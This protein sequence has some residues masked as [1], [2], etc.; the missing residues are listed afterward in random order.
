MKTNCN[1]L[2]LTQKQRNFPIIIK[3]CIIFLAYLLLKKIFRASYAACSW[4]FWVRVLPDFLVQ[5][6]PI[7]HKKQCQKFFFFHA[8]PTKTELGFFWSNLD[9]REMFVV[10]KRQQ[11]DRKTKHA[12]GVEQNYHY[13]H[14]FSEL[15]YTN[16]F[17]KSFIFLSIYLLVGEIKL[18]R[19]NFTMKCDKMF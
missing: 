13:F 4:C 16:I 3:I 14:N 6:Q 2:S 1:F 18:E 9:E 12:K 5:T 15:R 17:S 7:S 11:I 8:L 10:K 19:I